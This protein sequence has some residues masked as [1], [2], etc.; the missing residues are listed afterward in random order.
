MCQS[1]GNEYI[2]TIIIII[3]KIGLLTNDI[4]LKE[5]KLENVYNFKDLGVLIN[6]TESDGPK[7][8]HRTEVAARQEKKKGSKK[9]K[10]VVF[11][12]ICL[13]ALIFGSER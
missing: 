11:K 8:N 4:N 2:I 6:T 9:T 5:T 1:A 13:S 7:V 10:I 12:T 3:I